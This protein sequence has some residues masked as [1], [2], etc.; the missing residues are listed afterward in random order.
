M[1]S[2]L[3]NALKK[4]EPYPHEVSAIQV[5]ETH[6]SWILLTG[7]RAYK[8]KKPLNLG[9]LDFRDLEA[10]RYY[11]EE[12][13]RLNRRLAGSI[14][15]AVVPITGTADAPVIAGSGPVIEYALR[16]HQFD[17]DQTLDK[18]C[19]RHE[20]TGAQ[21]DELACQIAEFH[22]SVPALPP[23]SPLGDLALLRQAMIDNFVTIE[24]YLDNPDDIE[25]AERLKAWSESKFDQQ[26]PLL[27][28]RVKDGMVRECHGD[29][30]LGNVVWYQGAITVFDCIEFNE[31]FRW[32]D[33]ANDL[34][35]L[36]MDLE[37]RGHTGWAFRALNH[38]LEYHGDFE[39]LPL[40]VM[41]KA[42]RAMVRAKVALLS[43]AE[44]DLQRE[45]QR[46]LYQRYIALVERYAQGPEPWLAITTGYSASGKSHVGAKLAEHFGM[47]RLRSDV[48]RK[49]LFALGPTERSD[50]VP[51]S[52]IYTLEATKATYARL[53]ML[54]RDVLRA[55]YPVVVDSA[56]L[57][58]EER[59]S[60]TRVAQELGLFS[61][62]IVCEAPEAVL[63]ERIRQRAFNRHEVSEAT[64]NILERQLSAAEPP[65]ISE[66][67]HII[68][69]HTDQ[70]DSFDRL[71]QAIEC[72]IGQLLDPGSAR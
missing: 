26:Q 63:R 14:Y 37:S 38:Y 31:S 72:R 20:L 58:R 28:K 52:G 48:E 27:S 23:D 17:P 4:P 2:S 47:I 25:Q 50:S 66:S 40:M 29:L 30:H 35:F 60:L 7:A 51:G 54:A 8:L 46:R 65:T 5:V 9:F 70:P 69:V 64:E 59:E 22:R 3:I 16:M 43:P 39:A 15:E 67:A 21:L 24:A 61:L 19:D 33:T 62:L 10:R 42:Y 6:I 49:R 41:F 32:I 13:L 44:N 55:G 34:A 71:I 18:L 36:I 68:Y 53:G 11:C 56:A 1:E 12:E 45:E 57:K